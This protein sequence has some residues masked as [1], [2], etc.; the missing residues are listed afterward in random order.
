MEDV[1]KWCEQCGS[2]LPATAAFCSSCGVKCRPHQTTS[3]NESS[4]PSASSTTKPV[5]LRIASTILSFLCGFWGLF[6][7]VEYTQGFGLYARDVSCTL[8]DEFFNGCGRGITA[9]GP[10]IVACVAALMF[11]DYAFGKD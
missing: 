1:G 11:A 3:P 2:K 8:L 10:Q 5:G 4:G 6:S 7:G 9:F